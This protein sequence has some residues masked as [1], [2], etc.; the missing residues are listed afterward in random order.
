[1]NYARDRL[2]YSASHVALKVLKSSSV[3]THKSTHFVSVTKVGEL[4]ILVLKN[5]SKLEGPRPHQ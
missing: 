4:P 2:N 3:H 5:E 1:M